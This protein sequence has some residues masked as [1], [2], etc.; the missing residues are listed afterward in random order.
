[1]VRITPFSAFLPTSIGWKT[2][3]YRRV[4]WDLISWGGFF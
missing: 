4:L 3:Y 1:M 2:V